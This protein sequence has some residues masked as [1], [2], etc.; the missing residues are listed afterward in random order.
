MPMAG[1]AAPSRGPSVENPCVQPLREAAEGRLGPPLGFQGLPWTP[2]L[3]PPAGDV[4][5]YL[6]DGAVPRIKLGQEQL[7]E[8]LVWPPFLRGL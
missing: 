6:V 3:C 7:G 5:Q 1:R 8:G 4:S 2:L